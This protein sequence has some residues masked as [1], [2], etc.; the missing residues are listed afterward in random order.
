VIGESSRKYILT[1]NEPAPQLPVWDLDKGKLPIDEPKAGGWENPSPPDPVPV[2][3]PEKKSS[4]G[5]FSYFWGSSEE[6][7]K[8]VD[9]PP[10]K[11]PDPPV[12]KLVEKPAEP[13]TVKPAEKP[14]ES[15]AQP[16]A[17]SG[18][19][20]S[21]FFSSPKE[22]VPPT[23]E[24]NTD[25]A[26]ALKPQLAQPAQVQAQPQ[27]QNPPAANIAA[28]QQPV[29]VPEK[30]AEQPRVV[31]HRPAILD[32]RVPVPRRQGDQVIIDMTAVEYG[33][34]VLFFVI[35]SVA[36]LIYQQWDLLIGASVMTFWASLLGVMVIVFPLYSKQLDKYSNTVA[37]LLGYIAMYFDFSFFWLVPF[38]LAILFSPVAPKVVQKEETA[39]ASTVALK[40]NKWIN[41]VLQKVLCQVT[42]LDVV[43]FDIGVTSPSLRCLHMTDQSQRPNGFDMIMG[44]SYETGN[45]THLT[46]SIPITLPAYGEVRL[47][48]SVAAPSLRGKMRLDGRFEACTYKMIEYTEDGKEALITQT[49]KF[50]ALGIAFDHIE[51]IEVGEL[52]VMNAPKLEYL[53]T[54]DRVKSIINSAINSG[55]ST[56]QVLVLLFD[57]GLGVIGS[58]KFP[59]KREIVV[60]AADVPVK[61]INPKDAQVPCT[62]DGWQVQDLV[63]CITQCWKCKKKSLNDVKGPCCCE[64]PPKIEKVEPKIFFA[65]GQIDLPI[66]KPAFVPSLGSPIVVQDPSKEVPTI[67]TKTYLPANDPKPVSPAVPRTQME[68]QLR[69]LQE[70]KFSP[71]QGF[72]T[73]EVVKNPIQPTVDIKKDVVVPPPVEPSKPVIPTVPIYT[74]PSFDD[75]GKLPIQKP[76]E[77]VQ[78]PKVPEPV[79][80]A[81]PSQPTVA[82]PSKPIV[83]PSKPPPPSIF[84][85]IPAS[86]VEKSPPPS[87]F[88]QIPPKPTSDIKPVLDNKPPSSIF[89]KIPAGPVEPSKPSPSPAVAAYNKPAPSIDN[90]P[91]PSILDKI[92]TGPV[93]TKPQQP[94]PSLFDKIPTGPVDTKPQ[95]PQP[96]IF[97][98]IPTGPVEP[99]K[100]PPSIFDRIPAGPVEP[101]KPSP[102]SPVVADN[103]P[104]PSIDNK[105][106]PSIFDKIPTGPV[107]TKPQQPQPSIFD[108][109]PPKVVDVKPSPQPQNSI[110]EKVDTSKNTKPPPSYSDV[111]PIPKI[112]TQQP[113]KPTVLSGGGWGDEPVKPASRSGGGWGD[114]PVKPASG[115][116]GGWGDE[117]KIEKP[118]SQPN[119]VPK[120]ALS[121]PGVVSIAEVPKNP[122][123][124]QQRPPPAPADA[125]KPKSSGHIVELE[126]HT[127]DSPSLEALRNSFVSSHISSNPVS[128]VSIPSNFD[129]INIASL[130]PPKPPAAQPPRVVPQAVQPVPGVVAPQNKPVDQLSPM[131]DMLINNNPQQPVVPP[132]DQNPQPPPPQPQQPAAD[133]DQNPKGDEGFFSFIRKNF[134][135]EQKPFFV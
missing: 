65:P 42:G 126:S 51:R 83:E 44:Y 123:P 119:E 109:I 45:D 110:F 24:K 27:I 3:V 131:R 74:K 77:P 5:F 12:V 121:S 14:E 58:K 113:S 46:L 63:S 52:Q 9:K 19:L 82:E 118:V 55:L 69:N 2:A 94:Q 8:A 28:V 49:E 22:P 111:V 4:G 90:K 103:K 72:P 75:K 11:L 54:F 50:F 18:G 23:S 102:S 80:I 106:P 17:S 67:I 66:E 53:L 134:L 35:A 68:S 56:D 127:K 130:S 92:P 88:D 64:K 87:I 73:I 115:S 1:T 25:Q 59:R 104:A 101:S 112:E 114:E 40:P 89:D 79:V 70:T 38:S 108:K 33:L 7:Q 128:V 133:K 86:S 6:K 34:S 116:G 107:D 30:P 32:H 122:Q 13:V 16:N 21:Y 132:K 57:S 96:S 97:D 95:Q 31:I 124:V 39:D 84:E 41:V 99:S 62:D 91:P 10:E 36:W 43:N 48:I 15:P 60:P 78:L 71:T 37:F 117:P 85:R 20:L 129:Q 98:K 76:P 93:D 81:K 125:V 100:P 135:L 61:E 105:P 29:V 120:P 26:T 47:P